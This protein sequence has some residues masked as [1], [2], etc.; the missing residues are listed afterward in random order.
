MLFQSELD[1][2][3]GCLAPLQK[4]KKKKKK[5]SAGLARAS[6]MPKSVLPGKEKIDCL[7]NEFSAYLSL[8]G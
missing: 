2:N 1:A 6:P 8:M 3:S 7:D 4:Q 5:G